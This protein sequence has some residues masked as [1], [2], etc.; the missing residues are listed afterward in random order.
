MRILVTGATGLI[1]G[2]LVRR[3]RADHDVFAISR[4]VPG[5][6]DLPIGRRIVSDFAS[7]WRDTVLPKECDAVVHLAQSDDHRG[8]P[9]TARDMFVV[10]VDS[11]SRLLD[12]A[13]RAGVRSF[14][15][16][17]TGG[18]YSPS[19]TPISEDGPTSF[20]GPLGFYLRTRRAA[21]EIAFGYSGQMRVLALRMFF[22]YGPGQRGSMLFPRLMRSVVEGTP[23]NL[24]G[25]DG[26][27]LNPMHVDDATGA[28]SAVLAHDVSGVLNLA[29][30]EV[31]SMRAVGGILGEAA[32][33]AAV[34]AP[35][36][37]RPE[38]R[39]ASIERLLGFYR[40]S[41]RLQDRARELVRPT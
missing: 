36:E 23:I 32:G 34:F 26:L 30:P 14:L 37:R 16:A 1:G 27:R 20:D 19:D 7:G 22:V 11:T 5:P 17:S 25:D 8:F 4:S 3:L 28:I 40:P 24:D 29:G 2:T 15:L 6:I 38:N 18:L 41:I 12:W 21:E 13:R 39:I 33:K 9:Q 10:N 35:S 31:L